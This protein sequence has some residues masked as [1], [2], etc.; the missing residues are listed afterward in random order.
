MWYILAVLPLFFA[1]GIIFYLL[2]QIVFC[3]QQDESFFGHFYR[4]IGTTKPIARLTI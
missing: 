3:R 1:N 4:Y 2:H